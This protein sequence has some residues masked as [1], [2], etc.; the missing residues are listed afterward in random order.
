MTFRFWQNIPP[1]LD[2]LLRWFGKSIQEGETIRVD[3]PFCRS[4][5]YFRFPLKSGDAPRRLL[6]RRSK[7]AQVAFIVRELQSGN[8]GDAWVRIFNSPRFVVWERRD[9]LAGTTPLRWRLT[10]RERGLLLRVARDASESLLSRNQKLHSSYFW[11]LPVRFGQ[12]GKAAVVLWVDGELRGSRIAAGT[13]VSEAVADAAYEACRDPRFKP[14]KSED[15]LRTRIEVTVLLDPWILLDG[16]LI[17]RDEIL[18]EKGYCLSFGG[19]VGFYLPEVFNVKRFRSLSGFVASLAAEKAGLRSDFVPQATVYMFEVDDFIEPL[20]SNNQLSVPL[21]L[22]GP[23][24]RE[25]G[26]AETTRGELEGRLRAAADWLCA[27]QTTDGS[28]PPVLNPLTGEGTTTDWPRS[29]FTAWA[30]AAVGNVL[31][32]PRYREASRGNFRYLSSILMPN[33]PEGVEER[34]LTLAYLGQH[35]FEL[36]EERFGKQCREL[37]GAE[38]NPSAWDPITLGQV[39]SFFVRSP[40][41]TELLLPRLQE[42]TEAGRAAFGLAEKGAHAANLALWAEFGNAFLAVSK[43]AGVSGAHELAERVMGWL[44][45]RQLDDGSFPATT[46]SHFAYVCGTGKIFEVLAAWQPKYDESLRRCLSWVLRMQY[47]AESSFFVPSRIRAK[48]L[49]GFRHD[50]LNPDLHIDAAGHVLLGGARLL[51]HESE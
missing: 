8:P 12:K 47:S 45:S 50:F 3:L 5:F 2:A 1:E 9:R 4:E 29:A 7:A 49:G 24:V 31:K 51:A 23:L 13:F 33:P 14:L 44:V 48:V 17:E 10:D 41:R 15:L 37:I 32:E 11:N 28:F 21:K 34:I 22:F 42:L 6:L 20:E 46:N 18:P 30:L 38:F 36:G 19:A 27:I 25:S 16:K 26:S 43:T 40:N 39:A 35:A